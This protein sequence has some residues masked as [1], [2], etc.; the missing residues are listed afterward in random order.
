MNLATAEQ[1]RRL[2]RRAIEELGIPSLTLM[3][4]AARAVVRA[5]AGSAG[6]GPRRA[7]VFCGTGNNGGDGVAAARLLREAGFEVRAFL[8]GDRARITPDCRSMAD[9]LEAA[10][11]I[12]EDFCPGDSGQKAWVEECGVAVDALFGIGLTRPV[13]GNFADAIAL[14]NEIPAPVVSADIPS[15]VET[16]TGRVLGTAVRADITVTFTCPKIGHFVGAGSLCSGRLA[17]ADIGIPEELWKELRFD[18]RVVAPGDVSLPHRRRDAHKGDFGRVSILGGCVGYTGAPVLAAGAAV[19]TG[20]GLV[21]V[22]VPEPVWPTAAGKLDCAMP[23]PLPAG[24]DGGLSPDARDEA[25]ERIDAADTALIG[26]GLGRGEGAA[27]T[28]RYLMA[29]T[30]T[31]LVVDADGINALEGHIHVLDARKGRTTVLTPHDGEF[32]RLGGDLSSGDRLGEARRFAALHGCVLVLKG[33]R[34]ITALPDGTAFVNTTGNPGMAKGG[35]GDVLAGMIAALLGQGIP[36]RQA[37][38]WAVCLHGQAG[39]LAAEELGEYGMTPM[40]LIGKIPAV[41]K[42]F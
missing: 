22:L 38:P 34:T 9:R 33:H 39:D 4:Q 15:G 32:A 17:V 14:M 13:T 10:G 5:A 29:H 2:D 18:I 31:P 36:V 30:G 1:M 26:P 42:R 6:D 20:A 24:K 8:V 7:A 23:R 12:L 11:G 21:T 35:S 3:E 27:G 16:D 37:V 28:V 40:D 19:R 41:L 25:L